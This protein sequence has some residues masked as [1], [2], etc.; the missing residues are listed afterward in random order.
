MG[1]RRCWCAE[2]TELCGWDEDDNQPSVC[3]TSAIRSGRFTVNSPP[4]APYVAQRSE[5]LGPR[6]IRTQLNVARHFARRAVDASVRALAASYFGI[7]PS[8]IEVGLLA[9][10]PTLANVCDLISR[11][12]ACLEGPAPAHISAGRAQEEG[13]V[14]TT[15]QALF[16]TWSPSMIYNI[17]LR[18][19]R[20]I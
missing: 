11:R 20:S 12:G 4:S 19:S 6:R 14:A 15:G 2:K 7:G 8:L 16:G 10:E 3:S 9:R 1:R 5:A 13:D 18:H 17:E